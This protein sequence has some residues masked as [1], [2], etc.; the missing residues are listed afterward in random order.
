M[1]PSLMP[2]VPTPRNIRPRTFLVL[3]EAES[4]SFITID[5]QPLTAKREKISDAKKRNLIVLNLFP[6]FDF[7]GLQLMNDFS[8]LSP[9]PSLDKPSHVCTYKDIYIRLYHTY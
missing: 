4:S 1:V 7:M 2:N 8:A 3:S 6:I 5:L 9:H